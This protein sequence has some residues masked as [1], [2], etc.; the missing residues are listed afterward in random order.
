MKKIEYFFNINKMEKMQIHIKCDN[1]LHR[2]NN[3]FCL[4]F[5]ISQSVSVSLGK[6]NIKINT[7]QL[8][9]LFRFSYSYNGIRYNGNILYKMMKNLNFNNWEV[10]RLSHIFKNEDFDRWIVIHPLGKLNNVLNCRTVP[11]VYIDE[12]YLYISCGT[13]HFYYNINFSAQ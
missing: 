11:I 5:P 7:Q 13:Q 10:D 2:S 12:E 1:I 9:F 6:E 4:K 3:V 8:E